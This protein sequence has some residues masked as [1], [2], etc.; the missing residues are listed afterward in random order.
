MNTEERAPT[1]R[2]AAPIP[3]VL[4]LPQGT[5]RHDQ[6]RPLGVT[7]LCVF[8]AASTLMAATASAALLVPGTNLDIMWKVNPGARDGFVVIGPPAVMLL[9]IVAAACALSAVGLWKG[10]RWGYLIAL[11][12]LCINWLGDLAHIVLGGDLRTAVGLPIA[13]GMILYLASGR[14]RRLFS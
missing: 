12:V 10:A 11:A 7:L 4:R 8:F 13:G 5:W 3:A 14:V 2:R 6:P 9:Q 1:S